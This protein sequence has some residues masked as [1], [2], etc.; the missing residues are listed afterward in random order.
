MSYVLFSRNSLSDGTRDRWIL[1]DL[2]QP[3]GGVIP[4]SDPAAANFFK[5]SGDNSNAAAFYGLN[6]L[7]DGIDQSELVDDDNTNIDE[8]VG[9]SF[10]G[11]V[12]A[13]DN[14]G[15][16]EWNDVKN[17][18]L[19]VDAEDYGDTITEITINGFVDAR[20]Q[21]G[22]P[23]EN[24]GVT[25]GLPGTPGLAPAK[26]TIDNVKRGELN[27]EG[28]VR[29]VDAE[30][31]L[32]TN[33]SNWQ[34]S[35]DVVGSTV[36][37][38]I[39]VGRG[40]FEGQQLANF[41]EA[42]V[43]G[44][45]SSITA[46][47]GDGNDTFDASASLAVSD[48][49]GGAGDDTI[50]GSGGNDMLSGGE[51]NDT[52]DGGEGDD[53]ID[54]GTGQNT[55][56]GGEGDD[57]LLLS[58]LTDAFELVNNNGTIEITEI[59]TGDVSTAVGV[60]SFAFSDGT[61]VAVEDIAAAGTELLVEFENV[62]T[63]FIAEGEVYEGFTWQAVRE[64]PSFSAQGAI[65]DW[66]P[67]GDLEFNSNLGQSWSLT[68]EGET[69][70]FISGEFGSGRGFGGSPT[71]NLSTVNVSGFL[72]GVEIYSREVPLMTESMES[73]DF[74]FLGVDELVFSRPDEFSIPQQWSMDDLLFVV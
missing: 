24:D 17:I 30:I 53:M 67:D 59:A 62:P 15:A 31:L 63:G 55:I 44:S 58:G 47:L 10:V 68:R 37:D 1:G 60:E 3:D 13:F 71:T 45:V 61:T 57:T 25:P 46:D 64:L 4:G 22:V 43:D 5:P 27:L 28:S 29:G 69:F 49:D 26:V 9:A 54:G 41:G 16:S 18:E 33:N 38:T 11:G 7:S 35:F 66:E 8:A 21:L 32:A 14:G 19:D 6:F 56:D 39:T 73:F 74:D 48:V 23:F 40:S 65:L 70:D 52:I 50:I 2:T 20:V 12:L 72:D 51:G 34:N 36:D 42:V